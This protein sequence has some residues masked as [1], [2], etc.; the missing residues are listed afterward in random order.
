MNKKQYDEQLPPSLRVLIAISLFLAML[1][2]PIFMMYLLYQNDPDNG[3]TQLIRTNPQAW[4]GIPWAGGAALVVVLL[5]K[6]LF[7]EM[8]FKAIGIEFKGSSGPVVL[9]VLCFAA[10]VA[11]I[12]ALYSAKQ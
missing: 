3:L 6:P 2:A 9:W 7:G 10:E 4:L 8:E 5:F 12:V 11:G 1:G